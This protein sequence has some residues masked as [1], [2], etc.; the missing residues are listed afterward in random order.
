MSFDID[1]GEVVALIGE[2]GSGKSTLGKI[3]L[4]LVRQSAGR[5]MFEGTDLRLQRKRLHEYY[6]HVQGVFQDPFSS[7]NP[8]YKAD[9]VFEM[10]RQRVLSGVCRRRMGRQGRASALEA[11]ALNPAD[12]LTS[13]RTSFPAASSSAS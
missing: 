1:R 10:L 8:L 11:V 7:Y 2:S 12:V 6:R 9:R 4:R 5:V 13:S 3:V